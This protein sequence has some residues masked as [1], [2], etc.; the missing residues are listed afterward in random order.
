MKTSAVRLYGKQDLR[1]ETFDLP[2]I[3][4]GEILAKVVCD[5][6]CMSTYKTALQGE[7]HKRV[8]K[9]V[10]NH[11]AII[12]HEFCGVL[13][14]IGAKWRDQFKSG[15]KFAIQP[16][17]S[18]LNTF[19][20]AGYSFETIGGDATYIVIPEEFMICGSLL[21]Y[22]GEAFFAG[23]LSEPL[24]CVA[25][26]F[27]AMYHTE[28]GRYAHRM[29]ITPGGRMAILAGAGP[30]GLAA[31]DYILHTDRRPGSLVV[32]D[33]D[34]KRLERA[35][36][37]LPVEE[38]ARMGVALT[39]MN[40]GN[41][42]NP[43]AELLALTGGAGYDDVLVFAPVTAVVEQADAI[44][45]YDGCLNFFAGPANKDF[46]AKMNFYDVHYS[47]AHVVGTSGGNTEDMSECLKMVGEGSLTPAALITHVGGLDAV[48]DTTLNLPSIP[49]GKKIIYTH[50]KMPLTAIEDFEQLGRNDPFFQRLYELTQ[51]TNGMWNKQAEDYLLSVKG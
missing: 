47:S 14:Q 23:A 28:K 18:P 32:T 26:T 42:D 34:A 12:G 4:D 46:F 30:M 13:L 29:G 17:L 10:R 22:H 48:I 11:P 31:V 24:S 36:R 20:T 27:K 5:S 35:S 45:G 37:I 21:P 40:T 50:A 25:G 2:E 39:Y 41:M 43:A 44:L 49:G 7:T 9:D 19:R 1:L 38:A 6:L 8:P 33:I 3:G 15:D 16:T 51:E